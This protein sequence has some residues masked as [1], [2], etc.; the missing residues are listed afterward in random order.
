MKR[1][2]PA[3]LEIATTLF[4]LP[5]ATDYALAGGAA[6][7]AHETIDRPTRDL[8]AFVQARPIQPPGDVGPLTTALTQALEH[9]G[10]TV[11][12]IRTHQT[13]TRV[14]ATRDDE[15]V[16]IDFAVDSPRLFPTR[17]ID[18][19]PM[20]DQ[21]DL[22]AR[23]ILA[24]LDRA[25]GRDFTDLEAL[26]HSYDREDIID[27]A[28]QLDIGIAREAIADAFRQLDRLN[29]AE[30]PTDTPARTRQLFADWRAKLDPEA[31]A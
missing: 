4:A 6:L 12:P 29:D 30:L 25:E 21:R 8:D 24:I 5:E 11:T 23:K 17:D 26:Q 15:A 13:F 22:A 19:I 9:R 10:W 2:T 20:L 16:E 14:T 28:R 3:Q 1:L 31:G 18:G 7:L 27:W